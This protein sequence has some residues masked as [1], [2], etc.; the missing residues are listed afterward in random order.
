[1]SFKLPLALSLAATLFVLPSCHTGLTPAQ[2]A[3]F[4]TVAVAKTSIAANAYGSPY[5]G[6]VQ[7]QRNASNVP[8]TGILGPLV[9]MAIGSAVAGA[10]DGNFVKKNS[11]YFVAVQKNIPSNLEK[12]LNDKLTSSV[13]NS[14][15]FRSKVVA[16]SSNVITSEITNYRLIRQGKNHQKELLFTAEVKA[17]IYLRDSTGKNLVGGNYTSS[18]GSAFTIRDYA[19]KPM[20]SREAY[21]SAI[22]GAVKIFAEVLDRSTK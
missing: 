8:A 6:D 11:G 18:G 1:M 10:Q 9:G 2:R 7:M 19:E 3:G 12:T 4:S 5:G 13:K 21:E 20:R 17:N 15:F 16:I 22:E 14:S